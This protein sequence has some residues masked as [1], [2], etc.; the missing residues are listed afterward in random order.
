MDQLLRWAYI[1]AQDQG[2]AN[3][4]LPMTVKPSAREDGVFW[5]FIVTVHS[6]EGETLTQ[7]S[8]KLDEEYALK[9]EYMGRGADGFPTPQGGAEQGFGRNLEIRYDAC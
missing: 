4:G 6:R 5:G 1:D 8:V 2:V 7:L 3:F 9:H